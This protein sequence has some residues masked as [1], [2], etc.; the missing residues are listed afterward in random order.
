MLSKISNWKL[1]WARHQ[2]RWFAKWHLYLGII[3][4]AIVSIVGITGSILVFQDEIDAALNPKLYKVLEQQHKISVP[5]IIP[6][7]QQKHPGLKINYIEAQD[8]DSPNAA[9]RAY[10]FATDEQV[11]IN[12]YNG[13]LSGKRL[14][15]G[16]FISIVMNIHRTL[17]IPVIGRYIVALASL[18]LIILT[19]SGLRMWLPQKW[20]YLKQSLTINFK[21]GFKR[22]NYDWHNVLGIYSAPIIVLIA[23]TGI[24]ITLYV[25]LLPVFYGLDGKRPMDTEKLFLS[26][27]VY[28]KNAQPLPPAQ[29]ASLAVQEIK[30]ATLHGISMP[31][32]STGCYNLYM[33]VSNKNPRPHKV[34]LLVYDQYSGKLLLDSRKDVPVAAKAFMNWLIPIH[35]GA[36]GG[37]P[38][39]IL[40]LLSG[41]IP[42]A[43]FITGFIIWWPRYKRRKKVAHEHPLKKIFNEAATKN[44]LWSYFLL[45]AKN[46]F[47]YALW[48]VLIAAVFGALYGLI[49]GV[50]IPMAVFSVC[51]IAILVLLNFIV[52]IPVFTINLVVFTPF[53]KGSRLVV[54]YFALSLSFFIVFFIFYQLLMNTGLK[55]F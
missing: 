30:G 32:D 8:D 26:K 31:S 23:A 18:C 54:R 13:E 12:P 35:Y 27:S 29:I 22:K 11:F 3:A 38:T 36:F 47:R 33:Q 2:K 52:A 15:S 1:N 40:A 55:I 46:G 21:A 48:I 4:G 37:M 10:S 39:R 44:S 50:I 24:G 14:N 42:A 20:K 34:E 25:F 41:L 5:E 43:L 45:N 49:S 28:V 6:I 7:V 9:Y 51:Y 17:L 19:I 53:K 16:G